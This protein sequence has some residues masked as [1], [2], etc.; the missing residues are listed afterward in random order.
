MHD[1]TARKFP[2]PTLEDQS[3]W[4]SSCRDETMAAA[5]EPDWQNK[6]K[7]IPIEHSH[8]HKNTSHPAR[9]FTAP[10]RIS[11]DN[12]VG[13]FNYLPAD[14]WILYLQRWVGCCC[15]CAIIEIF[16][17]RNTFR[18]ERLTRYLLGF[19]LG[20]SKSKQPAG[21]GIGFMEFRKR[22]NDPVNGWR[23]SRIL[24]EWWLSSLPEDFGRKEQ[25]CVIHLT[26]ILVEAVSGCKVFYWGRGNGMYRYVRVRISI[27]VLWELFFLVDWIEHWSQ[28]EL[29]IQFCF[30]Q[31]Q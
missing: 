2:A 7:P 29:W 27:I 8:M 23:H 11:I 6:S 17:I 20:F 12:V 26:P 25:I 16:Q 9:T 10:G 15:C 22:A 30:L 3:P 4:I 31:T 28:A 18:M 24:S 13:I 1:P 14:L 21:Q 5:P 19:R